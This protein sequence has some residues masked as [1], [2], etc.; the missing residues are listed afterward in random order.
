MFSQ[1]DEISP[2][3]LPV[4]G[5]LFQANKTQGAFLLRHCCWSGKLY[6]PLPQRQQRSNGR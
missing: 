4:T 2:A 1:G 6:L 5:F 3:L